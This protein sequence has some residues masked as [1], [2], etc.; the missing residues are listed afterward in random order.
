MGSEEAIALVFAFVVIW[1][2]TILVLLSRVH[3]IEGRERR[4][5]ESSS[6]MTGHPAH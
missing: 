2:C 1:V 3:R 4:R 5:E 6:R